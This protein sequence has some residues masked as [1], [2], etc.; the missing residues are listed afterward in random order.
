MVY[1]THLWN[2]EIE[3]TLEY[4]KQSLLNTDVI[5]SY[6]SKACKPTTNHDKIHIYS[7]DTI[8][9]R[10]WNDTK[11]DRA[12]CGNLIWYRGDISVVDFSLS[13]PQYDFIWNIDY[14][15]TYDDWNDFV[16]VTNQTLEN[17][18][19]SSCDM[20]DSITCPTWGKWELQ[21]TNYHPL[22]AGYFAFFGM[23]KKACTALNE[24]YK[25]HHGYC[26]VITPTLVHHNNMV[27]KDVKHV[28]PKYTQ[29]KHKNIT[30]FARYTDYVWHYAHALKSE[31]VNEMRSWI[32]TTYPEIQSDTLS[33]AE[34]VKQLYFN[35]PGGLPQWQNDH[36]V[37]S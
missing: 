12:D 20:M 35:Y 3:S 36:P 9:A 21:S 7:E 4:M 26:E 28:Y 1:R 29:F 8:R 31:Q 22:V 2:A 33:P 18:D 27:C 23:S 34:V 32:K 15:V 17:V 25:T 14:D 13:N 37:Q 10:N 30:P 5:L 6:D 19:F 11:P 16:T 24:L